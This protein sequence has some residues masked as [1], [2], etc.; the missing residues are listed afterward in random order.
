MTVILLLSVVF[1]LPVSAESSGTS[2]SLIFSVSGKTN[3][4]DPQTATMRNSG[5]VID[6]GPLHIPK[7]VIASSDAMKASGTRAAN[8]EIYDLVT[9]NSL[10]PVRSDTVT[11]P[12]TLYGQTYTIN[13]KKSNYDDLGADGRDSYQGTISGMSDSVVLFTVTDQNLLYGTVRFGNQS[14]VIYPVQNR[15]YTARTVMPL[16]VVYSEKDLLQPSEPVPFCG[17]T[18]NMTSPP[19]ITANSE[20]SA[21]RGGEYDWAYVDLLIV[22]D[23]NFYDLEADWIACAKDYLSEANYQFQRPDIKVVLRGSYLV[24]VQSMIEMSNDPRSVTDPYQLVMDKFPKEYLIM[25]QK[26]VCV[27]L[28]GK[29]ASPTSPGYEYAQGMGAN[30]H[31][32]SQ[33]VEDNSPGMYDGNRHSRVYNFIHEIGHTLHAY[34]ELAYEWWDLVPPFRHITVMCGMYIGDSIQWDF[35]SSV[36]EYNG[37]ATHDNAFVIR[38]YK[39]EVAALA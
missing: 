13:L 21:T 9:F 28:G 18:D 32:W 26:D 34:H 7:I 30:R 5:S 19:L 14:I 24:S 2:D 10:I 23:K 35:S 4:V 20:L 37:D 33:M 31:T 16:H 22:T 1:I 15:E 17:N 12:I 8:T 36:P 6:Y 11:M 39:H 25:A 27:Y 29:D 38:V 3:V